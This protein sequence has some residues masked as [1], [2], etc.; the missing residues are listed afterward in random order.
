MICFDPFSSRLFLKLDKFTFP[1]IICIFT[2]IDWFLLDQRYN[3]YWSRQRIILLKTANL[4][5]VFVEWNLFVVG[6]WEAVVRFAL[7]FLFGVVSA[8][9]K[10]IEELLSMGSNLGAGASANDFFDFFPIFSVL[11]EAQHEPLMFLSGPSSGL[12][13]GIKRVLI[14]LH[15]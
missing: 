8:F 5:C 11:H 13:F 7:F 10:F 6:V 3:F 1:K 9:L 12:F 2:V 4:I 15:I 14:C